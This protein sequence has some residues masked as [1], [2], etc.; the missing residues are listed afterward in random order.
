MTS[1]ALDK[2]FLHILIWAHFVDPV[3]IYRRQTY[4]HASLEEGRAAADAVVNS[5]ILGMNEGHDGRATKAE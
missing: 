1:Q 2:D 3:N 4:L 5:S